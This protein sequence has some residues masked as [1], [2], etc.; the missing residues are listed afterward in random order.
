MRWR[1]LATH[2]LI[3][4]I[5]A[6]CQVPPIS[7][8]SPVSQVPPI[9]HVP[10]VN[11][12]T[13]VPTYVLYNFF[14]F[15]VMGLQDQADRVKAKGQDD[16]AV[17]HLLQ[18]QAGLTTQQEA[19]LNSIASDWGT[20]DASVLGQIQTMA[21]SGGSASPQFQ[22][23]RSQ[24]QQLLL[25]HLSQLQTTY[26]PGS[27]YLLDLYVKRNSNISGPGVTNGRN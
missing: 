4:V 9:S 15:R 12:V 22:A 1:I 13:G 26:G 6:V 7:Q 17:R 10:P 2:L 18:K 20:K 16:S 21:A 14:F 3:F 8:I 11:S 5:R 23:L 25:D 19:Q 24:R 27:F